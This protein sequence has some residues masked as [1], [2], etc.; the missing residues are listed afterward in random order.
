MAW[1]RHGCYKLGS[2]QYFNMQLEK[3]LLG[4]EDDWN[5]LDHF[6][7][8]SPTRRVISHFNYLRSVYPAMQDGLNLVQLGNWTR[9]E[10][11]P[12][13]N[14]TPTEKGWWSASRSS[15]PALQNF[16]GNHIDDVWLIYT[17]E[18]STQSFQFNC[19]SSPLWISSPYQSGTT[20][21]NLIAPF[22]SY[23][24]QPSQDSFF[25][26]NQTPF[27]GCLDQLTLEPF[28]FKALVP[29]ASWVPPM[30]MMTKFLPGHDHRIMVAAGDP[31]ATNIDISFEYN[32]AM[33]CNSVT[34]SLTFKWSSSGK[35]GNVTVDPSSITCAAVQN[36]D[37]APFPGAQTSA[38]S[39]SGT[40]NNVPDGILEL[41]LSNVAAQG[42]NVTTGVCSSLVSQSRDLTIS[43]IDN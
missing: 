15:I 29:E 11:L 5:S 38:W 39:W 13:S 32:V 3:A 25:K 8:T 42:G 26:N 28:S 23:Q 43:F 14:H 1:Q 2:D 30:P 19:S 16:T 33:D 4:C 22:E 24:L 7:P 41:I 6:D 18:N 31:N 40:L 34:N 12:G 17:N 20:V 27:T 9:M 10:Q 37:P 35:G 36:P 21:R